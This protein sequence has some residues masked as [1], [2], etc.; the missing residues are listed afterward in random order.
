[1]GHQE[2]EGSGDA[3]RPPRDGCSPLPGPLQ[4]RIKGGFLFAPGV[5][6]A[7]TGRWRHR[8]V[9]R[10]AF[11]CAGL[12]CRR[13]GGELVKAGAGKDLGSACIRCLPWLRASPS[14]SPFRPQLV[15]VV[16]AGQVPEGLAHFFQDASRFDF[17]IECNVKVT[18]YHK[19]RK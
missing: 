3:Q 9:F 19:S 2:R 1:M 10:T 16:F 12:L 17:K 4:P 6:G 8:C 18:L 5:R 13:L 11:G 7:G 14:S 15:P